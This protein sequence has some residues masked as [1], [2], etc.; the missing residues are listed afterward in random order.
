MN[1][2]KAKRDSDMQ[3]TYDHGE[4]ET[5]FLSSFHTFVVPMLR[6]NGWHKN[7]NGEVQGELPTASIVL[8]KDT[9]V[10]MILLVAE[11]M[12]GQ[13]DIHILLENVMEVDTLKTN[14]M[15]GSVDIKTLA[16]VYVL[17][18]SDFTAGTC[19][20]THEHYLRAA[21]H[22]I[23]LGALINEDSP[24]SFHVL[25]LLTYLEKH[26]ITNLVII[27]EKESFCRI[28]T[29]AGWDGNEI[30]K[31]LKRMFASDN[32]RRTTEWCLEVQRFITDGANFAT[33]LLPACEHIRLQGRRV[34]LVVFQCSC[35]AERERFCPETVNGCDEFNAIT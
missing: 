15:R 6:Q 23:H 22:H 10:N 11:F 34:M 5:R 14:L 3:Q 28:P 16:S 20:V 26:G 33:E 27:V 12:R 24:L 19:G 7:E 25:T 18:G 30:G 35:R 1:Y 4:L 13:G 8:S 29:Y 21:M 17:A 2:F 32:V 31:G 9:E